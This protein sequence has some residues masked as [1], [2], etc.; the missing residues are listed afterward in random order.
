MR[1]SKINYILE[2]ELTNETYA[3]G[4][5]GDVNRAILSTF[6]ARSTLGYSWRH[7]YTRVTSASSAHP[8]V[9]SLKP[10]L[11]AAG[12]I[13][14]TQVIAPFSNVPDDSNGENRNIVQ[15]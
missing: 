13:A 7:W 6:P 5:R 8:S 14:D 15:Q 4:I 2:Q 12:S 9:I 10:S 11:P 1:D 3:N